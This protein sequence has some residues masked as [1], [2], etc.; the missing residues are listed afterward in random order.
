MLSLVYDEISWLCVRLCSGAIY[1]FNAFAIRTH[2][3]HP[4]AAEIRTRV[5]M[6]SSNV[7][8][9]IQIENRMFLIDAHGKNDVQSC[10]SFS[11]VLL[12]P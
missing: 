10:E 5:R 4:V 2:P 8:C 7:E 9:S 6:C 1:I 3:I 12:Q 11:R